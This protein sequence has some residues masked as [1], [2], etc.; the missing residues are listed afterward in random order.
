MSRRE[1]WVRM[2]KEPATPW[3]RHG[4]YAHFIAMHLVQELDAHDGRA[5]GML[6]VSVQRAL[7]GLIQNRNERLRVRKAVAALQDEGL[8]FEHAGFVYVL[9][10][11]QAWSAYREL[12]QQVARERLAAGIPAAGAVPE[13][14]SQKRRHAANASVSHR[15]TSA[16]NDNARDATPAEQVAAPVLRPNRV[17]AGNSTTPIPRERERE[18]KER[19]TI[20]PVQPAAAPPTVVAIGEAKQPRARGK[21]PPNRLDRAKLRVEAMFHER[22]QREVGTRVASTLSF[23]QKVD[24]Q[25]VTLAYSELV[26]GELDEALLGAAMDAYFADPWRRTPDR[27][28]LAPGFSLG[29]FLANHA[30]YDQVVMAGGAPAERYEGDR[31]YAI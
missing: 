1:N 15:G 16:A 18:K 9:Y 11:P 2:P 31:E 14:L 5:E 23:R 21:R 12:G 8:I 6:E 13:A 28:G 22:Y 17:S 24:L 25:R 29:S 27:T 7:R 4:V 30:K 20:S 19:S 10:S 3:F 26:T